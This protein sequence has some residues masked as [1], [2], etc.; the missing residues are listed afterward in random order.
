LD[1]ARAQFERELALQNDVDLLAEE[2]NVTARHLT[3]DVPQA[4]SRVTLLNT[5]L[6]LSGP[7]LHSGG[8]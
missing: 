2:Y 5:A 8:G 6:G 4:K 7:V 1:K 3:G